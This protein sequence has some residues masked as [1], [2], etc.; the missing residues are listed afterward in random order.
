MDNENYIFSATILDNYDAHIKHNGDIIDAIL[1]IIIIVQSVKQSI[2]EIYGQEM[3]EAM[4]HSLI[5]KL[6]D[7]PDVVETAQMF[8]G[9]IEDDTCIAIPTEVM[10]ILNDLKNNENLEN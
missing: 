2:T 7:M 6:C 5:I 1:S 8:Y 9:A 10:R 4:L 3:A